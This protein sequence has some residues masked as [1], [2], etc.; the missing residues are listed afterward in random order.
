MWRIII[1]KWDSLVLSIVSFMYGMMLLSFPQILGGYMVYNLIDELFDYH[2]IG[3][4]FMI[5]GFMKALGV[6]LNNKKIKRISLVSLA[7]VWSVFSVSFLLSPPPNTV[8]VL[9]LGMALL[10]FGIALKE[11]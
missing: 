1:L 8:W 4:T 6:F 10:A 5:L 9:S 2:T 11:G 7:M 3:V